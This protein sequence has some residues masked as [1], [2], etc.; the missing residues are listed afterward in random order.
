MITKDL[1]TYLLTLPAITTITSQ[2]HPGVL[3][4]NPTLPAIVYQTS[5]AASGIAFDGPDGARNSQIQL[6]TYAATITAS[7]SLA[8]AIKTALHGYTG[9]MDSTT[10]YQTIVDSIYDVFESDTGLYRVSLDLSIWHKEA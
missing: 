7:A 5:G 2:I 8:E 9:S 10:V 1:R 3:P 6:D 4:Q